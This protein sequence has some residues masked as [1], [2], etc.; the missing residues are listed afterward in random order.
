MNKNIVKRT[1]SLLTCVAMAVCLSLNPAAAE[2][3]SGQD[4]G[5]NVKR[6]AL[7]FDDGPHP[8]KTNVILD[9][10]N[11]Y[12]V[13]ATFFVIGINAESYPDAVV[14]EAAEGHEIGNHTYSHKRLTDCADIREELSKT[15]DIVF[16]LTGKR[17]ALMRPPEGAYREENVADV[18]SCGC[19]MVLWTI[20]TRDW[21]KA[22]VAEI[23]ANVKKNVR[24]GSIILF[25]DYTVSGTHTIEALKRIIPYLLNEGYELVPVSQLMIKR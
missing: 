13:K 20:D 25:H 11:E 6:V 1:F 14:R 7:T 8:I 23:V 24:D 16:S 22:S 5:Q 10:L 12:N 21:A 9:V 19:D 18:K 3:Y 2:R 17:P 4:V 15:S